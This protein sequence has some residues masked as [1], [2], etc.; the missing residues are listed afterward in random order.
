MVCFTYLFNIFLENFQERL[1]KFKKRFI[2][3][4]FKIKS[5]TFYLIVLIEVGF[6]SIESITV[7]RYIT[8]KYKINDMADQR[9][10]KMALKSSQK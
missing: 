4:N 10:P 1:C 3:Y 6:P 7:T 8:Y 5:N 9:L 2:I